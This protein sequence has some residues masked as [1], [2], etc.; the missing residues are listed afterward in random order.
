MASVIEI[1]NSALLQLGAQAIT[2]LTENSKNG[3]ICNA[4]YNTV[5]DSVFRSHPWN[6]L[7]KRQK[8]AADTDTPIYGFSYQFTLPA[9]C[10]RVLHLNAHD[11]NFKVEGRKILCNEASIFLVYVSQVTDPNEM[12]ILLRE[13][14]SAAL[15]ADIAYSITANIGIA[16]T[17][18]EKFQFKLSEARHADAGEGQNT[19]PTLGPVDQIQ[20]DDFINS[21][22]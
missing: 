17:F 19:D 7:I 15:A 1:C 11:S 14:I 9:D 22:Y 4:R 2:A 5:R 20:A 8:L 6:S 3:R 16:N 18:N 13:T 12:D 21:R 10:L